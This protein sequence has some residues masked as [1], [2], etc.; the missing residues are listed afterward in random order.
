MGRYRRNWSHD[1]DDWDDDKPRRHYGNNSYYKKNYYDEW[2]DEPE[3]YYGSRSYYKRRHYDEDDYD[4]WEDDWDDWIEDYDDWRDDDGFFDNIGSNV[5]LNPEF[6]GE[7]G[8]KLSEDELKLLNLFGKKG[9]ILR[10][11]YIPKSNGKTTE[12]DLLYITQKGVFVLESKN[13][14]GWIFGNENDKQWTAT[15]PNGERRR[16][17][18]PVRQNQNHIKWLKRYIGANFP[19]YSVIVFSE[20]CELKRIMV[21]TPGVGVVKRDRLFSLIG[22]NWDSFPDYF[23][24]ELIEGMYN[25]LKQCTD[26]DEKTKQKHVRDIKGYY[27]YDEKMDKCPL[28]GSSLIKETGR[29]ITSVCCSKMPLCRYMT[30]KLDDDLLKRIRGV[31]P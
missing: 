27:E 24:D 22:D 20:R 23:T 17:Y 5:A 21:T 12:I 16:F 15:F 1:Y 8:E 28:C 11:A 3:S 30:M 6:I 13:Y 4:E 10:N 9:R 14:S 25:K 29:G 31:I 26:V 19:C 2:D 7:Y 18:N